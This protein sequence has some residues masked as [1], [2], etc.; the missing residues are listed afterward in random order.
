MIVAG[1]IVAGSSEAALAAE[2]QTDE[3]IL[4]FIEYIKDYVAGRLEAGWQPE[5]ENGEEAEPELAPGA[6]SSAVQQV[7]SLTN[8]ARRS[9]GLQDLKADS[10]LSRL[11]QQ[12]AEDM[13]QNGYFGH[14][15]PTYGS[16]FDMLQAAGISYRTAGENIAK[17]QSSAGAAVDGWMGSPGHRAN[18]LSSSF[19]E[20]GVG[21]AA[22]SKG[23]TYWVQIFKG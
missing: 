13:A 14:N 5:T 15:S 7:V 16:A 3:K 23:T 21:Y 11:A 18:I 22:D 2:K 17:G 19:S 4:Q 9:A 20:L 1:F 10:R 6:A 12:K 8:A